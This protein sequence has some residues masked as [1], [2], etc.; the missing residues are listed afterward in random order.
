MGT[1]TKYGVIRCEVGSDHSSQGRTI[2]EVAAT[3][4]VTIE[5]MRRMK[6]RKRMPEIKANGDVKK[7]FVEASGKKVHTIK[8]FRKAGLPDEALVRLS[9]DG[10]TTIMWYDEARKHPK[11]KSV[12]AKLSD[13]VR[14]ISGGEVTL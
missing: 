3:G 10:K 6:I 1:V 8:S 14:E 4:E 12:F 9:I 5:N 11:L 2:L 7:L 13:I